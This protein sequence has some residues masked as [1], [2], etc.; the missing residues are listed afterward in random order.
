MRDQ[1][2]G[3]F[4]GCGLIANC[5]WAVVINVARRYDWIRPSGQPLSEFL[6]EL[7]I[8]IW[9]AKAGEPFC[10]GGVKN[11]DLHPALEIL[12][13]KLSHIDIGKRGYR[14]GEP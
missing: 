6:R 5:I 3:D 8:G 2:F 7:Q 14:C 10:F 4:Q 1:E 12:D 9:A 11:G 13:A